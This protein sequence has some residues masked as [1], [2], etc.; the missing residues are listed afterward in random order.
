MA[1]TNTHRENTNVVKGIITEW[2]V[3]NLNSLDPTKQD[4]AIGFYSKECNKHPFCS[5]L[6]KEKWKGV[7]K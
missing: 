3:S 1:T 4:K 7:I 5:R 2:L 6:A